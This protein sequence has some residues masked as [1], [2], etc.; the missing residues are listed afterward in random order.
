MFASVIPPRTEASSNSPASL[1]APAIVRAFWA[2]LD[3]GGAQGAAIQ[4]AWA[5]TFLRSLFA[6]VTFVLRGGP[7]RPAVTY[8]SKGTSEGR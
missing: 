7:G 3:L 1:N 5:A 6:V 8:L 4:T 2:S